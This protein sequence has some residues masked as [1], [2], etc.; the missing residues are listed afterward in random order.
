MADDFSW[1]G[2]FSVGDYVRVKRTIVS[3]Q[4]GWGGVSHADIGQLTNVEDSG[5][6]TVQFPENS[7]WSAWL[8]ELDRVEAPAQ[9]RV[10]LAVV[11]TQASPS[12]TPFSPGDRVV[13]SAIWAS[14]GDAEGGP[15]RVGDVGTVREV[16]SSDQTVLIASGGATWW[17][18]WS[19]LQ[20]ADGA[21]TSSAPVRLS[22]RPGRG[23]RPVRTQADRGRGSLRERVR[24]TIRFQ[25]SRQPAT[26]LRIGDRVI[27]SPHFQGEQDAAQ[28]PLQPGDVGTVINSDLSHLPYEVRAPS[29]RAWWYSANALQIAPDAGATATEEDGWVTV[30]E[31]AAAMSVG[32]T[33]TVVPGYDTIEDAGSGPLRPGIV[34]VIVADDQSSKPFRVLAPNGS[35]WWYRREA[36]RPVSSGVA[37]SYHAMHLQHELAFVA[38]GNPWRCDVCQQRYDTGI[39]TYR[40]G[41]CNWDA[42]ARCINAGG[43]SSVFRGDDKMQWCSLETSRDGP[44]CQH[45]GGICTR[46]HWA[47]CGADLRGPGCYR[48]QA[49]AEDARRAVAPEERGPAPA[50][51]R[52]AVGATVVLSPDYQQHTDAADGPLRPGEIGRVLT[53]DRSAKPYRVTAPGGATW[54]YNE[55]A[56]VSATPA[57]GTTRGEVVT[58]TNVVIGGRVVRGPDWRWGD[59]D[60][61][62][63]GVIVSQEREGWVTVRWDNSSSSNTYRVMADQ[64]DLVYVAEDMGLA[65]A[66]HPHR[67]TAFSRMG[68][69]CDMCGANDSPGRFRCGSGCDYDLCGSCATRCAHR[70]EWRGPERSRWCSPAESPDGIPCAH[71]AAIT[72]GHWSCCGLLSQHG[73][74]CWAGEEAIRSLALQIGDLVVLSSEYR[75]AE[76]ARRGPL[77]PRDVGIIIEKDESS[78]PFHVRHLRLKS[79]WWYTAKAIVPFDMP[80]AES[81]PPVVEFRPGC[82]TMCLTKPLA[83][84]NMPC[85]HMFLC[86]ECT[87][88][89]RDTHGEICVSCRQPSTTIVVQCSHDCALCLEPMPS[90]ALF[91]VSACGHTFC[92]PCMIK[93]VKVALGDIAS[94]FPLRCPLHTEKCESRVEHGSLKPLVGY[95]SDAVVYTVE[96]HEHVERVAIES[97]IPVAERVY[98]GNGRCARALR[99][100][101]GPKMECIYCQHILCGQCWTSDH[102]GMTC[103]QART[104]RAGQDEETQNYISKTSKPC[105]NCQMAISHYRGHACHHIRPGTGCPNCGHHFCFAC[106]RPHQSPDCKCEKFC[107]D[108]CDCQ[109]C[110]ECREGNPCAHCDN[111]GRC[112]VC[113]P[114]GSTRTRT[115]PQ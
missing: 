41:T 98:C 92:K 115:R 106:L 94:Q 1:V 62:G 7:S 10:P 72:Q 76:D 110:P 23:E 89:F 53:D 74:G 99:K 70:G 68:Y 14:V 19:A 25:S 17:Y 97:L 44:L 56:L 24:D 85:A 78:K 87:T 4:F 100:V 107:S 82:C 102:K 33:V 5:R 75:S 21:S 47:C 73:G 40:C 34:G 12:P 67:L 66:A 54:W 32:A 6:C 11:A 69:H 42:C 111:D 29:G 105:P 15:L 46:V 13:L 43:H 8:Y 96:E 3:P 59:Q 80:V 57:V 39:M 83:V 113:R 79:T 103:A 86:E 35:S 101:E 104:Q 55:G 26:N 112:R 37:T 95:K 20:R 30:D 52:F 61:Q 58:S 48:A 71:G 81:A 114:P 84:L 38:S 88:T 49:Q 91:S 36:L 51:A 16:D 93:Y 45:A 28:G 90:H 108:T 77:K 31:P 50:A 109:D 18:G 2:M 22:P 60:G 63:P 9:P 65:V 64:H 27:L